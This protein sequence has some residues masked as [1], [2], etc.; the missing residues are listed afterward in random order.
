MA[1]YNKY[2]WWWLLLVSAMLPNLSGNARELEEAT[3]KAALAFNF[4]RYVEW[5]QVTGQLQICSLGGEELGRAFAK[6]Q[7]RSIREQNIVVHSLEIG[8][9]AGNCDLL[10]IDIRERSQIALLLDQLRESPIL[11][12]GELPDFNDYGGI[13]RLFRE[14]DKFRFSVNLGVAREAGLFISARLLQLAR[15]VIE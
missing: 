11:T 5:P 14:G 2:R 4:A 10:F 6:L 1:R 8:D 9:P 13:I 15:Q 12:I 7:G 3:A